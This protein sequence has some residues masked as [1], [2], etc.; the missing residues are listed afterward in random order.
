MDINLLLFN[1]LG[2][3]STWNIFLEKLKTN[4]KNKNDFLNYNNLSYLYEYGLAYINKSYKKDLGKYY[5]PEDVA[6][7]MG[8]FL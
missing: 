1:K 2:L 8:E 4:S 5:T 3:K 6:R 7:F